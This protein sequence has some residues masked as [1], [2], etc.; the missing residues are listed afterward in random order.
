MYALS[1]CFPFKSFQNVKKHPKILCHYQKKQFSNRWKELFLFSNSTC[2]FRLSIKTCIL[3]LLSLWIWNWISIY[4]SV[5]S[6]VLKLLNGT[7]GHTYRLQIGNTSLMWRM[8]AVSFC[9]KFIAFVS[10]RCDLMKFRQKPI[11]R[12]SVQRG[13]QAYCRFWQ[14][15]SVDHRSF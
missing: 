9:V 2:C 5:I 13:F 1:A 10:K 6:L 8:A 7:Y 15:R 11:G 14:V 12:L 4:W 3:L